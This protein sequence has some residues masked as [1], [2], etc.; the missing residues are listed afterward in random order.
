MD[1]ALDLDALME[2]LAKND[3]PY[4]ILNLHADGGLAAELH[5]SEPI[6]TA[7][8]GAHSM[9]FPFG[10][11]QTQDAAPA[12]ALNLGSGVSS[13]GSPVHIATANIFPENSNALPQALPNYN[14][15][16]AQLPPAVYASQEGADRVVYTYW[17]WWVGLMSWQLVLC[18]SC[19][20][21]LS[22]E[23]NVQCSGVCLYL[24]A[25]QHRQQPRSIARFSAT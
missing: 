6:T 19:R 7:N 8:D 15:A 24:L 14:Y 16:A 13:R 5:G 12:Q 10:I 3:D 23:T 2:E 11:H 21:V 9:P 22:R 18:T 17:R 4:G 25:C 20:F 1:A